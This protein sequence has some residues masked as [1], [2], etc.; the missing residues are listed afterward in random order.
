MT[1]VNY[2]KYGTSRTG[3]KRPLRG[4]KLFEQYGSFEQEEWSR[5]Y[6]GWF[7]HWTDWGVFENHPDVTYRACK[8][9]AILHEKEGT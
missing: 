9:C 2:V 8:K 7:H 4:G 3:L 1:D 5:C 6:F